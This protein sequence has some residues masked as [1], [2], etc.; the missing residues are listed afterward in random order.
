M[1]PSIEDLMR[2]ATASAVRLEMR[3]TYAPDSPAF[4]AW[5]EGYRGAPTDEASQA[6]RA[7]VRESAA[8]GVAVRRARIVSEPLSDFVRFEYDIT[9]VHNVAAGEQVRWLSR[10][11]T[12]G[13]MLPGNDFWIIDGRILR[14]LLFAGS[15]AFG[16]AVVIEGGP[17]VGP[18]TEIFEALWNLARP[19]EDYR[20]LG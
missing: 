5:R 18:Y 7:L 2:S 4:A 16:E 9:S 13:L 3:D 20:P 11:Y 17:V 12:S 19:H 1:A 6:W 8:R 10:R 14:F 15:G